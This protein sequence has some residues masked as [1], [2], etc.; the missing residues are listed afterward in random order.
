[1]RAGNGDSQSITNDLFRVNA[2]PNIGYSLPESN[3][4]PS[5]VLS[6]QNSLGEATAE[7][8]SSQSREA[9]EAATALSNYDSEPDSGSEHPSQTE[10]ESHS[11][12]RFDLDNAFDD[13]YRP[14]ATASLPFGDW[15]MPPTF[16]RSDYVGTSSKVNVNML[17]EQASMEGTLSSH[18]N[19]SM[20]GSLSSFGLSDLHAPVDSVGHATLLQ[21]GHPVQVE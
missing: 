21:S 5:R 4:Q 6:R 18:P 8:S 7:P 10:T 1:M 17:S 12:V 2:A 16:R 15:D 3:P 19:M 11:A 14:A 20:A 13:S 9:V